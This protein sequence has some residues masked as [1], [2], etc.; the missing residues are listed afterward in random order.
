MLS[1]DDKLDKS[2]SGIAYTTAA[3]HANAAAMPG[4]VRKDVTNIMLCPV[5]DMTGMSTEI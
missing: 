4:S 5:L 1:L 3:L 2:F